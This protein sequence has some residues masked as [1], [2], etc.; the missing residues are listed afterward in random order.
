V[1]TLNT[2]RVRV[3]QD[4][5]QSTGNCLRLASTLF[6]AGPDGLVAL[7]G[8]DTTIADLPTGSADLAEE[9]AAGCP[10]GVITVVRGDE[11]TP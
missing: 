8:S 7:R 6:A 3:N 9:A 11:A 5:C 2:I 10:Y 1:P 4:A